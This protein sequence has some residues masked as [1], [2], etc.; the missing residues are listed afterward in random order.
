[1]SRSF[2]TL[3]SNKRLWSITVLALFAVLT[4]LYV[5]SN[6]EEFT[7]LKLERPEFI[8]LMVLMSLIHLYGTGRSMDAALQPL[9][10]RLGRFETFG[11][12]S[13]TGLANYIAPGKM[14]LTIR[15]AYLKRKYEFPL[16]Q[17]ASSL[18]AA[19]LL[20]FFLSSVLGLGAIMVL[21][22]DASLPKLIPFA[23]LLAG[24][25]IGMLLAFLFSPK[26]KERNHRLYNHL[27][28]AVNGFH[29]IRHEQSAL[30]SISFWIIV[31][32][33][34][35]SLVI[36]SAFHAFGVEIAFIQALFIISINIFNTIIGITPAGIGIS[37]SL[38]VASASAVG[39][40]VPF[41]LS[42]ALLRRVVAFSVVFIAT[43]FSSHKL[44]GKSV[45]QMMSFQKKER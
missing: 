26:I 45:F 7:S 17:F 18:A 29:T 35:Q 14:G 20:T 22:Q 10:L 39:L 27:A 5:A 37:E 32:V 3:L 19:Q 30:I 1:M 16:T 44:F 36:Y 38:I 15:A 2:K 13:M 12:A 31:K 21:W 40:P 4:G 28:K 11:L 6:W 33:T 8:V 41:A 23:F 25:M 42:V 43:L 9:G 24:I 34:S